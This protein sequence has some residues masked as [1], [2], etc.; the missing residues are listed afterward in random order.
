MSFRLAISLCALVSLALPAAASEQRAV[1]FR[2]VV[3]LDDQARLASRQN[4]L[5]VFLGPPPSSGSYEV[6]AVGRFLCRSRGWSS[7]LPFRFAEVFRIPSELV[8]KN[9]TVSLTLRGAP[10]SEVRL[11]PYPALANRLRR[12]EEHTSELQSL[13]HL[14]CRLLLEKKK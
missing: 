2:Y 6:H 1:S 14:V 12:S 3:T 5:R 11:G 9:G 7:Q 4:E 13:R 8:E 10:V